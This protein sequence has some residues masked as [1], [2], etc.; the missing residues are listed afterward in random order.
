MPRLNLIQSLVL[1]DV[2][3]IVNFRYHVK[4]F[5][6]TACRAY[7]AA[8]VSHLS[9]AIQ[10]YILEKAQLCQPDHI[11]VCDGSEKGTYTFVHYTV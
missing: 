10:E 11:V 7:S 3:L 6:A 9:P 2:P 4:P 1:F 5:V 8:S